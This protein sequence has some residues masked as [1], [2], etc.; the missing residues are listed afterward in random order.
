MV[1]YLFTIIDNKKNLGYLLLDWLELGQDEYEKDGFI[2]DEV[3]E[4][5]EEEEVE[6]RDE[7]EKQKRKKRRSI[8]SPYLLFIYWGHCNFQSTVIEVFFALQEILEVWLC[9]WRRLWVAWRARYS[10]TAT[11]IQAAQKS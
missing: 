1:I 3:E 6:E 8:Y 4:D 7:Q 5:P 10:P 9:W 2:V 11:E